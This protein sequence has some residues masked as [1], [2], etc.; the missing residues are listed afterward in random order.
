ML[1]L[2]IYS[3]KNYTNYCFIEGESYWLKQNILLSF[4][5]PLKMSWLSP[6]GNGVL[7]TFEQAES[8]L[9]SHENGLKQALTQIGNE[10]LEDLL[11]KGL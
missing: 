2:R 4:V 11:Y 10:M 5:G 8:W 1:S 9:E 6:R 3:Q 7:M